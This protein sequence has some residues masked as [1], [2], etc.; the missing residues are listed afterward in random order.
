MATSKV[1]NVW[2]EVPCV[3][4]RLRSQKPRCRMLQ[5]SLTACYWQKQES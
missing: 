4:C 2:C 1:T 5:H 3:C